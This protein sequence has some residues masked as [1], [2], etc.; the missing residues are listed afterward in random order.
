MAR[1]WSFG[2]RIAAGYAVIVA[3]ALVATLTAIS[4][5]RSLVADRDQ[6]ALHADNLVRVARIRWDT[7]QEVADTRGYLLTGDRTLLDQASADGQRIDGEYG[8]LRGRLQSTSTSSLLTKIDADRI[9]YAAGRDRIL[10]RIRQHAP[11]T[12]VIAAE[13]ANI[14][15]AGALDTD[16]GQITALESTHLTQVKQASDR[17]ASRAIGVMIAVAMGTLALAV[18]AAIVL[19]RSLTRQV[20][21]AIGHLKDS[22]TELH[23][24]ANQQASGS[25]EQTT[26]MSEVSTTTREL[27][28]TSRQISESAQR[29]AQI[30]RD[31]AEAARKGDV[32]GKK[33]EEAIGLIRRHVDE[34]VVHMLDLGRKSQQIGG[35]LEILKELNEQTNILAINASIESAGVR[36]DGRRFGA[37]ADEIRRLADRSAASTREIRHLI[38]EIRSSANTTVMATEDGSKA[39]DAGTRQF[40]EVS[41]TFGQIASLVSTTA[42]AAREIELS[43]KQQST[44]IEQVNAAVADI[45]QAAR[46]SEVSSRQTLETSSRL[47]DV[48]E[49]LARL[50]QAGAAA[51]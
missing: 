49:E 31:T 16:L 6:V 40:A 51:R 5:V 32:T 39:V 2:R 43:T 48:S 27:L 26:A 1:T 41:V 7:A 44:A 29:V 21:K 3:L 10:A 8:R 28:A 17:A 45:A 9:A 13:E 14:T 12:D 4:T 11:R 34:V 24:A 25:S 33:A 47:A 37:V 36:E 30:A 35:I 23:A 38:E 46:E 42:E 22:S 19:T 50:I 18:F 20:G 15:R